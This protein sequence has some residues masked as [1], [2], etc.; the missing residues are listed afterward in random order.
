MGTLL[1]GEHYLALSYQA[2]FLIWA[3]CALAATVIFT[4]FASNTQPASPAARGSI[5]DKI[6]AA[7]SLWRDPKLWLLQATNITFGFAVGWLGAF[8]APDVL[9]PT[10]SSSFIGFAGAVLS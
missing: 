3:G 10:L 7:V 2:T 6:L 1:S 9:T 8:V 4:L 5:F